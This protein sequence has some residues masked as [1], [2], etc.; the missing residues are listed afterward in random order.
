MQI[1]THDTYLGNNNGELKLNWTGWHRHTHRCGA[2]QTNSNHTHT[3]SQALTVK[4]MGHVR[5]ATFSGWVSRAG[6]P[7][8]MVQVKLIPTAPTALTLWLRVRTITDSDRSGTR[9]CL[10]SVCVCVI[11]SVITYELVC[12]CVWS[13][14]Q[15]LSRWFSTVDLNYTHAHMG[16]YHK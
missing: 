16:M 7:P 8:S 4:R 14:Q 12:M 13:R 15:Q 5:C 3:Q 11:S 1:N 2:V 6:S 9:S 10:Y